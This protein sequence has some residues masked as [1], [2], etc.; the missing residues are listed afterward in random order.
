MDCVWAVL[1]LTVKAEKLTEA[2]FAATHVD[3]WGRRNA[4]HL[5]FARCALR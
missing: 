5:A 4:R 3:F 2:A 1:P